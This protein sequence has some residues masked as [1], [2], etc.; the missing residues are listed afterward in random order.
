MK[1]L[2]L[3]IL[4]IVSVN[5]IARYNVVRLDGISGEI[6]N[7]LLGEDTEYATN[8]SYSGFAKISVGMS[9]QKV[10]DIL[11]KP[12]IIWKPY[13]YTN[14]INKKNFIGYQYSRSSTSN[15][16]RLRQVYFDRDGGKV[17]EIINC[18][19]ID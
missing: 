8:Y 3:L 19:Y 12:L 6:W 13:K 7:L 14:F 9:Q 10:E 4:L 17:A 5:V 1:N 16:Y 2:I 15:N 18:F 11:G